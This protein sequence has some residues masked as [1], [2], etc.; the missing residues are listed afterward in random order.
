MLPKNK[1]IGIL[2]LLCCAIN[3]SA[4]TDEQDLLGN[5]TCEFNVNPQFNSSTVDNPYWFDT[6]RH[7]HANDRSILDPYFRSNEV[8][9]YCTDYDVCKYVYDDATSAY[10]KSSCCITI[11]ECVTLV[12]TVDAN[13]DSYFKAPDNLMTKQLSDAILIQ[14]YY[15]EMINAGHIDCSEFTTIDEDGI[16]PDVFGIEIDVDVGNSNLDTVYTGYVT[17]TEE[18]KKA[19]MSNQKYGFDYN[20]VCGE[21]GSGDLANTLGWGKMDATSKE[22]KNSFEVFFY[23]LIPIIFV[24]LVMKVMSKVSN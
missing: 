2:I 8:I 14:K 21:G 1:L 20:S 15:Q 7:L 9:D 18:A 4:W 11:E 3:V 16:S 23:I 10:I 17:L 6:N 12:Y 19:L 5:E 22:H 24:L 13:G